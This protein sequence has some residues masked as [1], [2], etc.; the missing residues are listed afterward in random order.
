MLWAPTICG[1]LTTRVWANLYSPASIAEPIYSHHSACVKVGSRIFVSWSQHALA[2]D[3]VGQYVRYTY[4]DDNFVSA[5]PAPLEMFPAPQAY[6][7]QLY[8]ADGLRL[9]NV[10]FVTVASGTY[11]LA[12]CFSEPRSDQ[13]TTVGLLYRKVD[14]TLGSI[15]LVTSMGSTLLPYVEGA[16]TAEILAHV[17]QPHNLPVH[18]FADFGFGTDQRPTQVDPI[19]CEPSSILLNDG[20]TLRFWR[21]LKTTASSNKWKRSIIENGIET[22]YGLT[23]IPNDP[24]RGAFLR[25]VDGRILFCGNLISNNFRRVLHLAVSTTEGQS[26]SKLWIVGS[27][28]TYTPQFANAT[29][30]SDARGGGMQYPALIEEGGK[31]HVF[32]SLYKERL[33]R[34]T[35][36]VSEI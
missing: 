21:D 15:Y 20:R 22:S 32:A 14:T 9:I 25:L 1:Q 16:E 5:T 13:R 3:V 34:N 23:A 11:A 35:I 4:S 31:L 36:D 8:E 2:E 29:K 17:S 27:N 6:T 33:L 26:W 10:G 28:V 18:W 19:L 7:G 30:G 12:W 24:S